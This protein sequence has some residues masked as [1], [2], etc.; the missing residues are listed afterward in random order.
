MLVKITLHL[1][2][3]SFLFD[4]YT[5]GDLSYLYFLKFIVA[6]NFFNLIF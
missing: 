1:Q 3:G 4:G 6:A 2:E 5:E